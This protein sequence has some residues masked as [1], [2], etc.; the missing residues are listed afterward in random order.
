MLRLFARFIAVM[1]L[2]SGI[3]LLYINVTQ[4][5]FSQFKKKEVILAN[6]SNIPE[7]FLTLKEEYTGY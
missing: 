4:T 1:I 2:F 6:L 7:I 3:Y 5:S